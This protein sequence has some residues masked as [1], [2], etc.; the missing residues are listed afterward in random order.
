LLGTGRWNVSGQIN[1]VKTIDPVVFFG[2]VGYVKSLEQDGIDLGNQYLYQFGTGFSLN[3]RVSLD[4]QAF[5]ASV[6][7]TELNGEEISGTGVDSINL[8]FGATALVGNNLFIA[9]TVSAGLTD[10]APDA[11]VGIDLVYQIQRLF[12]L[13]FLHKAD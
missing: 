11:A 6:R 2:G 12:P 10:D 9:P 3:D 1:M 7:R 8:Q 13:P 5:G 4:I